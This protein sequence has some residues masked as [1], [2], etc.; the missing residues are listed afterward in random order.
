MRIL[1][2]GIVRA[3]HYSCNNAVGRREAYQSMNL[4]V[5]EERDSKAIG[6]A[7][8]DWSEPTRIPAQD[9]C[10]AGHPSTRSMSQTSVCDTCGIGYA[11]VS[12]ADDSQVVAYAGREVVGD[13]ADVDALSLQRVALRAVSIS[14]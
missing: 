2:V 8:F 5:A 6:R 11:R 7:V 12:K 1:S 14:N 3:S 10:Q 4:E 13:V 9:R